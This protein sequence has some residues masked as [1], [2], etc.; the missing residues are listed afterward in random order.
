VSLLELSV[1]DLA[2]IEHVRLELEP[3]FNVISGETGAGKSLLI[4]A[5]ALVL[6]ARADTSLVRAGA[7][8]ARAEAL[9]DRLPEP[10][11]CVREVT[12]GGRSMARIDDQA[13]TAAR[14]AEVAAPLV[15]IHGQH[16]QQRLLDESRQRDLLD[17]Y[18]GLE[19]L[20]LE[21]AE[22]VAAWRMNRAALEAL[23][24][25][26]AELGRR[27]E[28]AEHEAAE[29]ATADLRIGEADEIRQRLAGAANAEQV[30]RLVASVRDRL[31]G[32]GSGA[33]DAVVRAAVESAEL[34]R[35]DAR[36]EALATRLD[37]LAAELE[38]AALDVR[39]LAEHLDHDPNRVAV[40]EER[41]G[42]IYAL[43]R[44]YGPDEAAVLV[45]GERAA[46]EAARLRDAARQRT[47]RAAD[48]ERLEAAARQAAA[49]LGDGRRAAAGGLGGSVAEALHELGMARASFAVELGPAALDASGADAVRFVIAPN[50]GEP[51]MPLAKI[52]SGG[53]LS[54]VSLAV[55][56][57]LAT[58]DATPT[59]VFDE[60]DAGIGSRSAEPVGRSLWGLARYH[61]VLTV[62]HLAQIAAY[63][64]AHFLISKREQGGRTVTEVRR[65]DL[66]GRRHE[67]AVMLAGSHASAASLAGAD[68]L[69][70]RAE[71]LRA[72]P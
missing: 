7:T 61:Q 2:L 37:G 1:T 20:R 46:A 71:V 38:D 24:I 29:I 14:L 33:R 31:A 22:A 34:A 69:L 4:D 12:A 53:E 39:R 30:G 5:L 45:H 15:E 63:A 16:E 6:G 47:A 8:A 58:A 23:S 36:F 62:T 42:R 10:L 65:L 57:V 21:V 9:F 72:E 28:L 59:L 64:D 26:P 43:E 13:A 25:D 55:K 48:D 18:G 17:A 11:I 40:L 3:G 41:L 54:R 44:K 32:E 52:A 70:A 27:V 67:L 68:E 51:A 50:P 60:I 19:A 49:R 56:R 35:L 66:E